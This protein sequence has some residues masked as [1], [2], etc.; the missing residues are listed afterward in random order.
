M[1]ILHR[2]NLIFVSLIAVFAGAAVGVIGRQTLSL[3]LWPGLV[4]TGLVLVVGLRRSIR[5]WRVAG[6]SFPPG[7]VDWLLHNVAYYRRLDSE[8]RTLFE[9]NARFILDE[10]IFEGVD[11]VRVSQGMRWS[12]AAGAA[13]LLFGR[14]DWEL[15]YHHTVLFY[16]GAFDEDY[17]QSREASFEGMAHSHGPV[18]LSAAALEHVWSQRAGGRNVVLHELAHLLDYENTVADGMPALIEPSSREAWK[19]LVRRE[20]ARIGDGRSLLRYYGATSPAE[21]FAVAVETFF[22]KPELMKDRHI[23]LYQALAVMLN[24]DPA[25]MT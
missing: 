13:L 15:P 11:G 24:L 21:F 25:E 20:M 14:P 16:P 4:T 5:R 12:V 3:S 7:V 17:L 6:R 8:G 23:E 18:I 2:S 9:R 19:K 1:R 10:W 22:E